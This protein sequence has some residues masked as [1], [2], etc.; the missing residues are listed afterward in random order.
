[1]N[2]VEKPRRLSTLLS[3]L[4]PM[5]TG[6]IIGLFLARVMFEIWPAQWT[7]LATWQGTAQ[8][9]GAATLI[10]LGLRWVWLWVSAR[11]TQ[12]AT[13]TTPQ[14][15]RTSATIAFLP[16]L[17]LLVYIL[18]PRV[19]LLMAG[20]LAFAAVCLSLALTLRSLVPDKWQWV[21]VG[22][23]PGALVVFALT[24]YLLTV[25]QTVGAADTFEFQVVA[26]TLGIAHPTGYPLLILIGKLFS[27]IPVGLVAWR[28][29]LVSVAFAAMT[30]LLLYFC[31][32][33]LTNQRAVS[34]LAALCLAFSRV[35]WSQAVEA[36]AY[37]LNA[38]FVAAILL[39]LVGQVGNLS[40]PKRWLF[41]LA[42][43]YG[44]S[45][46]NHLTM[47]ILAPAILLGVLLARQRLTRWDLLLAA[48]A[49][50]V[51]LLIDLY[52]PLRWPALHDGHW[53]SLGDFFAWIT[54]QQFRGAMQ[55]G[56]WRDPTR[57]RIVGGLMLD[58][59][60]PVGAALAVI[61]LIWLIVRQ[62]R[63]ALV[64]FIAGAGYFAYGLIY[65]VPDV[66]VFIIP[67]HIL[68]ALWIGV[69]SSFILQLASQL[70][71][72]VSESAPPWITA[73]ALTAF[74]LLPLSLAWT[75]GPPVD[76]SRVGWKLYQ[77]G[78]HVMDLAMPTG[79][80]ILADSEKIAPL[81][82]LKRIENVR[83]DLDTLVLGDEGLYRAEL[84]QRVAKGQPVYLARY[85]PGL[86][87]PYRLHSLGPLVRVTTKPATSPPP[88]QKSLD[89]VSWGG[90]QISLLGL[91]VEPGEGDVA[92]RITLYWQARVKLSEN[93]HVRLRW[94]GPSGQVWWQDYGAHPVG[95]YN[96][97][98]AWL[99]GE[100]VADYHEIPADA[101]IPPGLLRLD[102]GL[103][104]PFRDE[105]LN[106]DGTSSP[107]FT[108]VLLEQIPS[109]GGSGAPL[110]NQMRASFGD[111][112][113]ITGASD[114]G[115]LPPGE[116]VGVELEWMRTRPGPDRTLQ[117][118]WT[119]AR[120]VEVE[121]EKGR[122]PYSAPPYAG[123]YPTSK[124]TVGQKLRARVTLPAPSAP[125]VY[126]LRAGWLD[127]SGRELAARCQ[128]LA[129]TTGD[130]VL[131]TLRVEGT[132]RGQGLN[133]D[134]QVLLLDAQ[135]A[136]PEMGPNET[137][138][139]QIKWQGLRQWNADY[140]A[141]VHLIGPD[142]KL[143]GQVDQWPL[144]GTLA[145]RDWSPGRVVDDAYHVPLAG[146]APPGTY[147]VE[148]GWYLLATLRRLP[149]VDAEGR[150]VDD[151]VII[152]T[153]TVK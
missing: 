78:R 144:D 18:W 147:Q 14:L 31:L 52:I 75:N 120:G 76:Q 48:A 6:L 121:T 59:F 26:P 124:W 79:S 143:H 36:E 49:F 2:H 150:P 139:V 105:G 9:A 118:R 108:L 28:V 91:D 45:F 15:P 42:A 123:E 3:W 32:L 73:S 51:P 97:T 72:R 27:L 53:M 41:A 66:S 109:R 149:V 80:A 16:F 57:W 24:A 146:D 5:L 93:Y 25:G 96:P 40:Y 112:L 111:E 130:C 34:A 104:L 137:L 55:F 140:T 99:P 81:Y 131:G 47:V 8:I 102:V 58:A 23:V 60:G 89:N 85:L 126:T 84:D 50:F 95:G 67:A 148:V 86:A 69:G 13:R 136:R 38:A 129:P 77:W 1:L 153:V 35:F 61:G 87:G 88:M 145:T 107:W 12:H 56:L 82:Y 92:W 4:P 83:P 106:R 115:V 65:N 11:F 62:W 110:A 74:A 10:L 29:N 71:R 70:A 64:T 127:A 20:I 103:F 22:I 63:I 135:I 44:L 134:N 132:A 133:F 152:G 94:R 19:N 33:H 138:D 68:M 125:G 90:N 141:F 98:T 116:P 46:T 30:A 114:P 43:V 113:L 117:L 101:T 100:V 54:G 7:V 119:D 122:D 142:G 128:W 17:I 151:R 21:F 39:L 37:P